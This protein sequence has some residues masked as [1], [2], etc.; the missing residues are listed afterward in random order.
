MP[1]MSPD[2]TRTGY[3]RVLEHMYPVLAGWEAWAN[4]HVPA[5]YAGLLAA[6]QRSSLLASDLDFFHAAIPAAYFPAEQ[7]PE[8]GHSS[9]AFLGAMYVIEGSTLGGQH[10]AR[11]V[12][13][14]LNLSADS[15]TA[16]FRGYADRTAEQWRE[17]KD[18]LTAVPESQSETLIAAA[19]GTFNVFGTAI[20]PLNQQ[21]SSL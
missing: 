3:L 19:K 4:A 16:Y 5:E 7:I 2:L 13:P 6:R 17:F 10:I 9:A 1:L 11:H 21:P 20:L 15:G 8:L 12:E 18:V 14:L